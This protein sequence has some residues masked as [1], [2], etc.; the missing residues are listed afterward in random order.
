MKQ[1]GDEKRENNNKQNNGHFIENQ[2]VEGF[3]LEEK[4]LLSFLEIMCM[5]LGVIIIMSTSN[6]KTSL[7]GRINIT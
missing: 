7:T 6:R 3:N 1:R 4:K 5:L 2:Y